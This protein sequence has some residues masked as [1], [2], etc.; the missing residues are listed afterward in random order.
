MAHVSQRER[1]ET[2]LSSNTMFWSHNMISV[3][4]VLEIFVGVIFFHRIIGIMTWDK[5]VEGVT[6]LDLRWMTR[7]TRTALGKRSG[8]PEAFFPILSPLAP[9]FWFV[10]LISVNVAA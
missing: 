3:L 5:R 9:L 1:A 2:S 6:L 4:R 7:R 8:S 10:K